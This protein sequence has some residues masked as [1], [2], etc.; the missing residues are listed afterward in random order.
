MNASPF[1]FANPY[2]GTGHEMDVAMPKDEMGFIPN[3]IIQSEA[4]KNY[5]SNQT[6]SYNK[7]MTAAKTA[8]DIRS[9][10]PGTPEYNV[11][12]APGER[13]EILRPSQRSMT[14]TWLRSCGIAGSAAGTGAAGR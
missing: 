8:R 11:A 9:N 7:Y 2:A 3:S 14:G 1:G 6:Q 5:N 10:T 4:L 12:H 13:G